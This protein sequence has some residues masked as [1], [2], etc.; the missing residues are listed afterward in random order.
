MK[1]ILSILIFF[2]KLFIPSIVISIIVGFAGSMV[3]GSFSLKYIG[4]AF[5]FI[6]PLIHFFVYELKNEKEY[7]FYYNM[8]LSKATLWSST[9]SI[10]LFICIILFLI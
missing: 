3:T 1:F 8:G 4:L 6:C 9:F 2:G 7:Y 10:S 5:L